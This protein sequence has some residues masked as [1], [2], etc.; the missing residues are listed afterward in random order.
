MAAAEVGWARGDDRLASRATS[1]VMGICEQFP[2]GQLFRRLSAFATPD[3]AALVESVILDWEPYVT[4][5]H[6][7]ERVTSLCVDH[8]QVIPPD[9][10]NTLL[11]EAQSRGQRLLAAQVLRARGVQS[12]SPD[13]L[14][15]A[16][17]LF[18]GFGARPLVA[19]VEIELGHL[20]GDAALEASGTAALEA[21]GDIAQLGRLAAAAR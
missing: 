2:P 6:L 21:L 10:L 8:G 4:R 5:L 20:L 13:D 7:V 12:R 9:A 16:L 11:A 14:Q 15:Q 17:D 1:V 3:P 19:R 18:R